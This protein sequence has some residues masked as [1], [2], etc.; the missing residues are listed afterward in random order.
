MNAGL[1][2]S[3]TPTAIGVVERT[4]NVDD[5]EKRLSEGSVAISSNRVR[6][7]SQATGLDQASQPQVIFEENNYEVTD[8]EIAANVLEMYYVPTRAMSTP[9]VASS[10]P[11]TSSSVTTAN[12]QSTQQVS[13]SSTSTM[14]YAST[15]SVAV[16]MLAILA[17]QQKS[18]KY[19]LEQQKS[20]ID[21]INLTSDLLSAK[22]DDL[23]QQINDAISKYQHELHKAQKHKGI[24]GVVMGA[25]QVVAALV[26]IGVTVAA[27]VA[28]GGALGFAGWAAII[29]AVAMATQGITQATAAGL[30]LAGHGN[31]ANQDSTLNNLMS[32]GLAGF[33]G[34]DDGAKI[35][36]AITIVTALVSLA[37]V[38]VSMSASALAATTEGIAEAT[39]SELAQLIASTL[40]KLLLLASSLTSLVGMSESLADESDQ[41]S[42]AL[43]MGLFAYLLSRTLRSIEK[44][45]GSSRISG[46]EENINLGLEIATGMLSSLALGWGS[47]KAPTE[48]TPTGTSSTV[49]ET[50]AWLEEKET[51]YMSRLGAYLNNGEDP[52]VR[53]NKALDQLQKVGKFTQGYSLITQA[54]G[55]ITNLFTAQAKKA[56]TEF[57]SDQEYDSTIYEQATN[58]INSFLGQLNDV[59][60]SFE[61]NYQTLAGTYSDTASEINQYQ[62]SILTSA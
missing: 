35:S 60:K 51:E 58:T 22:A 39:A 56:S 18:V 25:L 21:V 16:G 23:V 12:T 30:V 49:G 34:A 24:L 38:G 11:T 7:Q 32:Y 28:S 5:Y 50:L 55:S 41:D 45:V 54:Q 48:F 53:L 61:S 46:T 52:I 9:E 20:M 47:T 43:S 19:S 37:Q 44:Q 40:A 57:N 29:A 3:Y 31:D 62:A 26:I 10:A 8:A 17:I 15:G 27:T 42:S 6:K 14:V 4:G 36:T 2:S 33:A 59:Y 13:S 1:V